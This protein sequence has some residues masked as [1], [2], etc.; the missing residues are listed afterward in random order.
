MLKRPGRSQLEAFCSI[1]KIALMA[2]NS[3]TLTVVRLKL[4]VSTVSDPVLLMT[5]GAEPAISA[6]AGITSAITCLAI[7]AARQ[8]GTVVELEP[9]WQR[10]EEPDTRAKADLPEFLSAIRSI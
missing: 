8:T 2:N 5:T 6:M 4:R 1:A 7:D 9:Y 3:D 10:L